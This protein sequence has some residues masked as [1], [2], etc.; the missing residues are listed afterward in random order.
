[1]TSHELARLLLEGPDL[2][3]AL[4]QLSPVVGYPVTEIGVSLTKLFRWETDAGLGSQLNFA[5]PY[6]PDDTTLIDAVLIG[7]RLVQ[8]QE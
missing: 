1:M 3:V 7:E 2:P 8:E 6:A 4:P 5:E